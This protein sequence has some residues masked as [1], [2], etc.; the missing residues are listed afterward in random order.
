MECKEET[1][2]CSTVTPRK[3]VRFALTQT[4]LQTLA[5]SWGD[6]LSDHMIRS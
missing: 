6:L 2:P 3:S 1:V 4:F 5:N